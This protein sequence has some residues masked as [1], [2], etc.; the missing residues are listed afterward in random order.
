[1][2][3]LAC[4]ATRIEPRHRG[5]HATFVQKDQALRRDRLD[6]RRELFA[7]LAVGLSVAFDG[8][9]RLFFSRRPNFFRRCQ[10]R[11]KLSEIPASP[12]NFACNSASVRS[13]FDA[14]QATT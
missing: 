6:A 13:G 9:E 11:P 14:T 1:M 5:S 10:I 12:C 3:A 2:D 7:P 4:R 8:V